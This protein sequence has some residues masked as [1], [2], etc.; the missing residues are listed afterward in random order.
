MYSFKAR[1]YLSTLYFKLRRRF[2]EK[3]FLRDRY[4]AMIKKTKL[5]KQ[6]IKKINLEKRRRKFEYIVRTYKRKKDKFSFMKWK[7]LFKNIHSKKKYKL[8]PLIKK[9][10]KN[11]I[12]IH[13][14]IKNKLLNKVHRPLY[15]AIKYDSNTH[16]KIASYLLALRKKKFIFHLERYRYTVP[17]EMKNG[18]KQTNVPNASRNLIILKI[19]FLAC[20]LPTGNKD[21]VFRR[22]SKKQWKLLFLYIHYSKMKKMPSTILLF[23]KYNKPNVVREA[24]KFDLPVMALVD[25]NS[26]VHK[27]S[28][29]IPSNDDSILANGFYSMLIIKILLYTEFLLLSRI[30][31]IK[32]EKMKHLNTKVRMK[33]ITHYL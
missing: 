12:K 28:Y 5:Y 23:N 25:S 32:S 7:H 4:E 27:V 9:V 30:L 16:A 15:K 19:I 6:K 26:I 33:S 13:Q 1:Y 31:H 18:V 8:I 10:N 2:Y 11:N 22:L 20:I 17:R 24:I 21:S 14:L 29:P 3:L